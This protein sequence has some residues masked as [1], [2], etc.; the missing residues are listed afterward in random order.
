MTEDRLPWFHCYPSKLL[1]AL[2]SMNSDQQLVYVTVLLRIYEVRGPCPDLIS[3]LARRVGF[4]KRR[5]SDA[6]DY[7]YRAGKLTSEPDGL[8][9]PVARQL[10][11]AGKE[12]RDRQGVRG[13]PK[14]ASKNRTRPLAPL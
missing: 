1:G 4:N 7:L 3:A 8:H 6:L 10:L 12:K 2:S 13:R 14:I 11:V 9:N 5:V